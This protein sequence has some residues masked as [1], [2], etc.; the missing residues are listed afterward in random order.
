MSVDQNKLLIIA[1]QFNVIVTLDFGAA[2]CSGIKD[3]PD[4]ATLTYCSPRVLRLINGKDFPPAIKMDDFFSLL[5]T[6][7]ELSGV[8]TEIWDPDPNARILSEGAKSV[9]EKRKM[10]P[11]KVWPDELEPI[12][13]SC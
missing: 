6:V 8:S 9:L 2:V 4:Q 3:I 10:W 12:S 13:F 7:I 5:V 11:I 1:N